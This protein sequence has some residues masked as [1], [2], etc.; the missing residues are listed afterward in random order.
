MQLVKYSLFSNV[1]MML[2]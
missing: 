1:I 2:L